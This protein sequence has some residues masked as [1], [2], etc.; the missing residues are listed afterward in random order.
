MSDL[1]QRN[2]YK[3]FTGSNQTDGFDKINLGYEGATSEIL[4]KKDN[5]TYFHVPFFAESQ[6]LVDSTLIG[7][8]AIPGPIPAM[9]DRILKKQGGYGTNTPWGNTTQIRDG[10]WLCSW[11]YAE[12]GE[13]PQWLDRYFN[14]GRLSVKR[15]LEFKANVFDYETNI[16]EYIKQDP[17]YYD[18]PST[19]TLDPGVWYQY[20]HQGENSNQEIVKTYNGLSGEKIRIEIED[21]S[22]LCPLISRPVDSSIYNNTIT[23]DNFTLDWIK[24]IS[25]PGYIGRSVLN[26]DNN[27][28][29]NCR[30]LY[31]SS[32]NLLNEFTLSMWVYNKNWPE[33]T[34][35][36]LAGNVS[37]GGYGLFY[38]DLKSAPYFVVPETNYGHLFY[39]NQNGEI[40]FERNLQRTPLNRIIPNFVG[41]NSEHE[42]VVVD[43]VTRRLYKYN[44]LGEV[45]GQSRRS[46]GDFFTPRGEP[47]VSIIDGDNNTHVVTTSGTYIFD[48][49]LIFTSYLSSQPYSNNETLA[50]NINGVLNREPNSVDVKF[51]LYG[52]KWVIKTD[53]KLYLNN[54]IFTTPGTVITN[55]AIDPE[56]NLWVL[57]DKNDIY[58]YDPFTKR[59]LSQF[60]VGINSI[61][62]DFKT[63]SFIYDYNRD[64]GTK[65]WYAIIIH[66]NEQNL[67]Q[68]TLDGNVKNVTFLPTRLD[69]K[70][71]ITE[72]QNPSL[73]TFRSKGDFTGYEWKRIF[74]KVVYDNKPQL[75]FKIAAQQKNRIF[76]PFKQVLS[77]PVDELVDEAWYLFTCTYQNHEMKIFINN[78]LAGIKYPPSDLDLI[79]ELKNDFYIGTPG[80]RTDNLNREI[81]SKSLIWNGY[82][83]TVRIYDY[84]L[85]TSKIQALL[86][87]KIQGQNI[88][89]SVPTAPL[90][91]IET[92]DQFFKHRLPGQKSPF[93]KLKLSGL[94][95]TD[96]VIRQRIESEI[97]LIVS[98]L[99]PAY[100]RLLS[101]EWLD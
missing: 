58:K 92:I 66:S 71:P 74:N 33:G 25:E 79:Y 12:P 65:T 100:S 63:I 54:Q 37:N 76:T 13:Q 81:N 60:K 85:T 69:I 62:V 64:L 18:V 8:G 51:D 11:L 94:K 50:F 49:N 3:I 98:Q 86:R 15:V 89:W 48:Q 70:Y 84:A 23:V 52:N 21:W 75:Q 46:N 59:L 7:D 61:T 34:S 93:F 36:Q 14:P 24:N 41:V 55:I 39:F 80:G 38:N 42:V 2:Y 44:H 43:S 77:V 73:L 28:F 19:M 10:T 88:T 95:I 82:I 22:C 40:Y 16:I 4:L 32:Y 83:D 29:I 45:L 91:Y 17:I 35:T 9:A 6:R 30:A 87:E 57:A 78:T 72:D 53:N 31:S 97:S 101:I 90:Q 68:T 96:P 1:I 47:R 56:N 26:F 99:S 5:Y 67:Y 27:D 20:F